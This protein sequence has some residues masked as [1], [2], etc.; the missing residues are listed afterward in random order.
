MPTCPTHPPGPPAQPRPRGEGRSEGASTLV[1]ELITLCSSITLRVTKENVSIC[2]CLITRTLSPHSSILF[3]LALVMGLLLPLFACIIVILVT[4]G[5]CGIEFGNATEYTNQYSWRHYPLSDKECFE[6]GQLSNYLCD[7]EIGSA[8]PKANLSSINTSDI[9][10]KFHTRKRPITPEEVYN[11]L[12]P[13]AVINFVGDSNT[14]MLFIEAVGF[15]GH[16]H[17]MHNLHELGKKWSNKNTRHTIDHT[18]L[19]TGPLP[20]HNITLSFLWSRFAHDKRF[21][22]KRPWSRCSEACRSTVKGGIVTCDES[23]P[24]GINARWP[25]GSTLDHTQLE[26]QTYSS[27]SFLTISQGKLG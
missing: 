17:W 15:F 21:F 2:I 20:P 6:C 1:N 13:N 3:L 8:I 5:G 18:Y 27:R 19:C 4:N 12:G 10:M 16:P 14:R 26:N 7:T 9:C 11:S 25:C 22:T 23:D 24:E